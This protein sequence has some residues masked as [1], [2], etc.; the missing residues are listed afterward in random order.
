VS[1]FITGSVI[2][3]FKVDSMFFDFSRSVF[4]SLF[5][6]MEFKSL[7]HYCL[8]VVFWLFYGCFKTTK[9]RRLLWYLFK[10]CWN[11]SSRVHNISYN[12]N[13]V[14]VVFVSTHV[15]GGSIL[16]MEVHHCF[17]FISGTTRCKFCCRCNLSKLLIFRENIN[18]SAIFR[19]KV[20]ANRISS[21]I[22]YV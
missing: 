5:H 2:F 19:R 18:F 3:I 22:L 4:N 1:E 20:V 14:S 12:Y 10:M 6:F 16:S 21:M 11:A 15:R 13:M 17:R 7:F 9:S 8:L